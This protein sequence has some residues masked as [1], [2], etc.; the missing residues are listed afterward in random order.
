MDDDQ[1]F[2]FDDILI[3]PAFSDIESRS[4]IDT[5][6]DFLGLKLSVPIISANMDFVTGYQMADR[7]Y[8][9]GGLGIIHR[10]HPSLDDY[11]KELQ[12]LDVIG[13]PV[14]FSV[15]IRDLQESLEFVK[16]AVDTLPKI[17]GVCIDVAH[18]HHAKV[19]EL[20]EAI[21]G[22]TIPEVAAIK[23]IAGN[24]ATYEGA[25]FL[26]ESGADGI[27][28]GI[29]AGSVCTTRTVA[30]VGVPQWS[31][32]LE[33][34]AIK[35]EVDGL[36]II[37]DGGMRSSGDI[38]KAIAAGADV[39]MLGNMLAG[40]DEA[41]GDLVGDDYYGARH[42]GSFGIVERPKYKRYRGQ[43]S[44][45][46]NGEKY[47]KEG[48]EGMVPYRGPVE[49]IIQ[50]IKAGLQSSMSYVGARNIP[51]F[52]NKAKVVKVSGHTLSENHTRVEPHG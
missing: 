40:T 22:N 38:A 52:W 12:S 48:I 29:G 26:Y 16:W 44:F 45:G 24:V 4:E 20:C 15:G 50:Q 8:E 41:P 2:T 17:G 13:N 35:D 36:A 33:C 5:S 11:K 21:K 32:I 30:G 18:G 51:E 14:F 10:F 3:V 34:A 25:K 9:L 43:A 23:V 31:A 42:D 37:A 1:Y 46:S 28:V 49:P 19:G 6:V 47:V 39:V 7:M 27:K